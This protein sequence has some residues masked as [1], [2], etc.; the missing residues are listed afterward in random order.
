MLGFKSKEYQLQETIGTTISEI[1]A[2]E[3]ELTRRGKA[4]TKQTEKKA[5]WLGITM[6][7]QKEFSAK[8]TQQIGSEKEVQ[9]L[10][11]SQQS[12]HDKLKKVI[13]EEVDEYIKQEEILAKTSKT[14]TAIIQGIDGSK[15]KVTG[16]TQAQAEALAEANR[17]ARAQELYEGA[18]KETE[19]AQDKL[20]EKQEK[21]RKAIESS[22]QFA[23]D[24]MSAVKGSSAQA[25]RFFNALKLDLK[26]TKDG[27]QIGFRYQLDGNH[28]TFCDVLKSISANRREDV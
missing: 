21:Q 8:L 10:I 18:V 12:E 5:E 9:K 28:R 14:W 2:I 7:M 24:F 1:N 20:N 26:Q 6:E 25:T 17:L 16:L 4:S 11:K 19:E 15:H 13:E 22:N 3:A 23:Q 27:L